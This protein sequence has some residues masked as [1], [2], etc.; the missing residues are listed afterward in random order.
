MP[1]GDG[2]GP[3]RNGNAAGLNGN[4]AGRGQ[5]RGTGRGRGMGYGA[6]RGG[7]RGQCNGQGPCRT[8]K[9]NNE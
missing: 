1:N 2:R 3:L 4:E 9:N 8:N 5:G 6:S 7:G